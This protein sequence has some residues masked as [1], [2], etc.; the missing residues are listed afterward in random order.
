MKLAIIGSRGYPYV[1]SGYETLVK[2]LSE[3]IATKNISVTVY[4]HKNLFNQFPKKINEINLVYI[5]TIETKSLS[6]FIHSFFSTVHAC[7]SNYDVI[8][9]LNVANGPFGFITKLFNIPTAINVDGLE[10]LRP[11]WKG[12]AS[13]YFKFSAKLSTLF[14]DKIITDS[15]E[16]QKIYLKDFKKNSVVIAYGPNKMYLKKSKILNKFNLKCR[17]FFLI[18]GR[19][20][21]DNN[22][23]IILKEF[24]N[25]NSKKKLVIVGDVPYKD[26]YADESKKLIILG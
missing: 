10:W 25:S 7:L 15:F 11:K 16:M 24:L 6:Q 4:C 13:K 19:L 8:L 17:N 21:P 1:Y 9:Y 3:R 23:D 5:P 20:I 18:I 2:E 26:F 22:A 14:I 12:I